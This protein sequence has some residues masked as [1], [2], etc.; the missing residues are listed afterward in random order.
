MSDHRW[1]IPVMRAG[2]AGRGVTYLAVAGVSLWAIWR[3][4]E[5]EGTGTVL[6]GLS[7]TGWGVAVLCLIAVGLFAYT[8]WRGLDA[9]EDLED[10]GT[11][12]KGLVARAGMVVTGL[13]HAAIAALA[14]SLALGLR[15]GGGGEERQGQG[16]IAEA[17]ETVLGWPGGRWIV[18]AA[19][20][21]TLG[22]GIYYLA[23]GIRAKYREHLMANPFTRRWDWALRAG[24]IANAVLILI[25]GGFLAA[26]AWQGSEEPAGGVGAAFDWIAEQPFGNA[27]VVLVCLGLVGF[28]F[29]CFVNAG[30]RVIPKVPH[31]DIETLAHRLRSAS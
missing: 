25:I 27:M 19:A 14:L 20:L 24:V 9:V 18:A 16:A 5:A 23:K 17:V 1:A 3:G 31:D 28:A 7:D 2:Y 11:E 8:V 12:A 30:Y 4:G 15:S 13:I 22:A 26:A 6:R 29:F 10:Y 21:C